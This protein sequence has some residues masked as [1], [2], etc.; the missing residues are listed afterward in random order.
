M[1]T[2]LIHSFSFPH[3]LMMLLMYIPLLITIIALARYVLGLRTVTVYT[4][5]ILSFAYFYLDT[6][7]T[8]FVGIKYG[9]LIT[10]ITIITSGIFYRLVSKMRMHYLTKIA[11]IYTGVILGIIITVF[12]FSILMPGRLPRLQPLPI[13]MIVT[14]TDRFV[15]YQIKK[16]LKTAFTFVS[17]GVGIAVFGYFLM[18]WA[19]LQNFL[20]HHP[21]VLILLMICNIVIGNYTG[22]R[23]TEISRFNKLFNQGETEE[24]EEE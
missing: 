9:L 21:E 14:L 15:A 6:S 12:A 10:A 1:Q 7:A 17:E 13:L 8:T 5:V 20:V 2:V 16:S 24:L 3:E 23:L 18:K 22:F 11:V 4:S 19:L